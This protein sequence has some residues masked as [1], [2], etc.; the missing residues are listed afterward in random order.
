[1]DRANEIRIHTLGEISPPMSDAVK[2]AFNR[3]K[4]EKELSPITKSSGNIKE[5]KM[6][7]CNITILVRK[8]KKISASQNN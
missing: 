2:W 5:H 6:T 7:F 3:R 8:K 4:K 1:M